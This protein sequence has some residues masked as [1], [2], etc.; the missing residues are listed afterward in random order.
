MK[1]RELQRTLWAAAKQ[2]RIGVSTPC[3]TGSA[4]VTSCGRR[5]SG[6]GEQGC[7]RGGSDHPGRGGGVRRGPHACVSCVV[8][9]ARACIVRRRRG[10]WRS[11]SHE[12]VSGRW[13]FRRCGTGWSRRRRR[14]CWNRSSRRTFMSCSYGFRPKRS[15]TQA[16]ERLRVG[17][18]EGYTFVVGVRHRQLLR[19]DRPR[20]AAGGGGSA[21]LGPAGA[22]TAAVVAAG[23]GD[24]GWGGARTVAGTR[25]AG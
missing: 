6:C 16:M 3:M 4:G 19:R 21:G 10:G 5:G 7:G 13:A 24:G 23:G 18:I 11:R 1:V 12:V 20:P 15:A 14:S 9:S 8:T 2:S 25:R 17:F 22:Q